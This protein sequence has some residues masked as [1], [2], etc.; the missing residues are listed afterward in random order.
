MKLSTRSTY[1]LRAMLAFAMQYGQGS[2]L[3]RDVA[4]QQHLPVTYLEQLMVPLRK[5]GLLSAKRGST[6]GYTLMSDPADISISA[7]I[8]ALEGPL[9]LVEG[10][11]HLVENEVIALECGKTH[12]CALRELLDDASQL[13]TDYLARIS[14]A[15]LAKR[16]KAIE[17][18]V[19]TFDDYVI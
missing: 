5:A 8:Q 10:P 14:L 6:G 1:G 19:L 16:Q 13:L 17:M 11:M 2:I 12:T 7:I 15:D 3:L 4:E 9:N 18:A